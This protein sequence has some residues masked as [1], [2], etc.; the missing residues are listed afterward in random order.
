MLSRSRWGQWVAANSAWLLLGPT[1]L[2]VVFVRVRL[3]DAPVERAE[4]ETE[5][6][7]AKC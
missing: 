3:R 5:M 4:G 2:F 7:K 1:L 6:V